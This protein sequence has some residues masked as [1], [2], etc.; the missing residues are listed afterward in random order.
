MIKDIFYDENKN[1]LALLSSEL[2]RAENLISVQLGS[3]YYQP[4]WG[5]DLQYFL[6]PDYEIQAE[7]FESYLL[8]QLGFWG[9]N[10][11]SLVSHTGQFVRSMIFNFGRPK[12]ASSLVRG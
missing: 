5:A 3:L 2:P 9:M 4:D 11:L 10:V 7:S 1:D 12:D 6:N 8:Q